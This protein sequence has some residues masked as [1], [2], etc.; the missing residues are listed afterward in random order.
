MTI[1][2]ESAV[3]IVKDIAVSRRFYEDLLD[4]EVA[5]DFGPNVSFA[6]G[7]F[8]IWQVGHAHEILFGEPGDRVGEGEMEIYFE[9]SDIESV[10]ARFEEAGVEF[11]HSLREQP[12]GQR[13]VRVY[14]PDRHIVE[15]GEPMPVV[16]ERFLAQGLSVEQTTERTSMPVEVVQKVAEAMSA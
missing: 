16:I 12:W 5:M 8:S 15:V 7:A 10:L 14:D 3:I 2:Y 13:V 11:V 4:Q 1:K 6:G 9:A